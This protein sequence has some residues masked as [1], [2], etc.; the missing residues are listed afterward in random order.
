MSRVASGLVVLLITAAS[1]AYAEGPAPAPS[2][3]DSAQQ[4]EMKALTDR[5]N[6][7]TDRRI[8][9][10]KVTLGLT[11][12]QEKYWPAVEEAMRARA[13]ARYRRLE[14]AVAILNGEQQVQDPV[15]LLQLRANN[16]AERA[17]SLKQLADAWQPLYQTLDANQKIRMRFLASYVRDMKHAFE[18]R[19]VQFEDEAED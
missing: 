19:Q 3:P 16:M 14:K 18:S 13:V 1:F 9:V 6:A 2:A 8:E 7:L 5:V 17:A 12:E 15:E 4:A 11:P 10:I